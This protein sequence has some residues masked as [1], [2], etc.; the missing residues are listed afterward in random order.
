MKEKLTYALWGVLFIVCACLGFVRDAAGFGKVL[1]V[2]SSLIFFL[3]GVLL[4]YW[5]QR[6]Q[7]RIISICS[8]G[9]TL[10]LLV[11]N[12]FSVLASE[13]VGDIL[14]ILLVLISSPMAC[15]QYWVLSLFLWACLLMAT[16]LK[17]NK[18]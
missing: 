16:F 17:P 5:G 11:A 9:A 18:K 2:L 3:P 6:K 12:F 4:L 15:S 8:L 10:V 1:L 14:Y 13:R 7:V